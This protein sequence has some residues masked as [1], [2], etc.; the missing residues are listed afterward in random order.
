MEDIWIIVA[1]S[2]LSFLVG[3]YVGKGLSKSTLKLAYIQGLKDS[4]SMVELAMSKENETK[5][6]ETK[7]QE[8]D[9]D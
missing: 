3:H 9:N 1:A 4:L 2:A 8:N 7:E 6:Q 5:N